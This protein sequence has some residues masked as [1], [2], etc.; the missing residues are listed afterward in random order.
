M[1]STYFQSE[2]LDEDKVRSFMTRVIND[3]KTYTIVY[4]HISL[5]NNMSNT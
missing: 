1:S 3:H 2:V 4:F 5:G